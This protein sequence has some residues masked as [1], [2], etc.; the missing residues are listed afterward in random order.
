MSFV[1]LDCGIHESVAV[2]IMQEYH[3]GV[4]RKPT[5]AEVEEMPLDV[6]TGASLGIVRRQS[7]R[8]R[9]RMTVYLSPELAAALT[10]RCGAEGREVSAAVAE[11]VSRWLAHG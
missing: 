6:A 9:R 5:D 10:A 8:V 2:G 4:L 3:R 11:A 7:G 1:A